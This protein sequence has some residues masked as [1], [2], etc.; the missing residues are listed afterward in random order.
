MVHVGHDL[1]LE[2]HVASLVEDGWIGAVFKTFLEHKIFFIVP[3]LACV[4]V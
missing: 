3:L 2:K 4:V 1:W